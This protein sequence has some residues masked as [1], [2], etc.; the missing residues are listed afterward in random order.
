MF[1]SSVSRVFLILSSISYL[2]AAPILVASTWPLR[3][4]SKVGIERMLYLGAVASFSSIFNLAILTLPAYSS[5]STSS[6]G[7]IILQGPHQAAQ[8]STSTGMS[9]PRTSASNELSVTLIILSLM[10]FTL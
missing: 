4:R 2:L 5:A 8:K 6:T 1:L 7:A 9:E 10:Y 3:K